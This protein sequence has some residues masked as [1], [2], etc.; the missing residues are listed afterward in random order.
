MKWASGKNQQNSL[1]VD[2]LTDA[3]LAPVVCVKC[4]A[5][6]ADETESIPAVCPACGNPIDLTTQ[7]A[8]CRGVNAFD[9]GQQM[10][11]AISPQ[12]RRRN[13]FSAE[14]ME[15]L[16]YYEQAYSSM[17]LAFRGTLAEYQR[18]LAIEIMAAIAF[19][20]FQHQ[21]ISSIEFSYWQSLLKELT[22][23]QEVLEV[24][25]KIAS[26]P[27]GLF[28]RLMRVR[29]NLR[30]NQLT[31]ALIEIDHK[32]ERVEASIAFAEPPNIRRKTLPAVENDATA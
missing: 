16:Q 3:E 25:D 32:I 23:Q 29:W 22:M 4:G 11:M 13:P 10:L 7:F 20:Q 6:Y 12:T 17:Q 8:Y 5:E 27:E 31:T 30:M 19:V 9:Y 15:S 18:R 21:A 1:P 2:A 24:K 28:K 14:E 26:L